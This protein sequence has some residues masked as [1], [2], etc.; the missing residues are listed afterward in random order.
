MSPVPDARLSLIASLFSST[1]A[2]YAIHLHRSQDVKR[3]LVPLYFES[4]VIS[5]LR[6]PRR[7]FRCKVYQ[8]TSAKL[9]WVSI[10]RCRPFIRSI[11]KLHHTVKPCICNPSTTSNILLSPVPP[12]CALSPCEEVTQINATNL[13]NLTCTESVLAHRRCNPVSRCLTGVH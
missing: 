7:A 4:F 3:I 2:L 10:H 5:A 9:R 1:A 12:L 8:R 11:L 13:S 6:L